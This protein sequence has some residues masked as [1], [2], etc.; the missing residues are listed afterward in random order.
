MTNE[1]TKHTSIDLPESLHQR[2]KIHLI[3]KGQTLSDWAV[4]HA[5][6]DTKPLPKRSRSKPTA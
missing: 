2:L 3:T 1:P 6:A 4:E 5:E